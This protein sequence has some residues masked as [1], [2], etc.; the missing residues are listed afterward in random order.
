MTDLIELNKKYMKTFKASR[1]VYTSPC[2]LDEDKLMTDRESN[3][4]NIIVEQI[5][6]LKTE[7]EEFTMYDIYLIISSLENYKKFESIIMFVMVDKFG[8][9]NIYEDI[10]DHRNKYVYYLN[11]IDKLCDEVNTMNKYTEMTENKRMK[12]D[13]KKLMTEVLEMKKQYY[14]DT[15]CF[16]LQILNNYEF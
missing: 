14:V 4:Y 6:D 9:T 10:E 16:Y 3:I 8:Y 15:I 11:K 13:E 5:T 2:N 1:Y 12:K 7:F